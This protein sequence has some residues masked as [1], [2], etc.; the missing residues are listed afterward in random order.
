MFLEQPNKFYCTRLADEKLPREP[1]SLAAA[2]GTI[3]DINVKLCLID[4]RL[5]KGYIDNAEAVR[6]IKNRFVNFPW[7]QEGKKS[8]TL[9]ELFEE[10]LEPQNRIDEIYKVGKR[11][12]D[13]Y[14]NSP[15]IRSNYFDIEDKNIFELKVKIGGVE[16]VVPIYTVIDCVL[17]GKDYGL[18]PMD[19]KVSG[20]SSG[21]SPKPKYSGSWDELGNSLGAHKNYVN[22]ISFELIDEAWATQGCTYGW[23]LGRKLFEPFPFHI[24]GVYMGIPKQDGSRSIKVCEYKGIITEEFQKLT[25]LKYITAWNTINAASGS[26]APWCDEPLLCEMLSRTEHFGW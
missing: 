4:N 21:A 24:H 13:A 8:K 12:F 23:S 14:F 26:V 18:F 11:L 9:I 15:L 2:A 6:T 7:Y 20:Y 3:F 22:D 17:Q 19:L 10:S 5:L 1:Q 16:H 25:A